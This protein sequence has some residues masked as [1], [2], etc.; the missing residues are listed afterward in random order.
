MTTARLT[1]FLTTSAVALA[2]AAPA[3]AQSDTSQTHQPPAAADTMQQAP[4]AMSDTG[5][6]DDTTM[7]AAPTGTENAAPPVAQQDQMPDPL[8]KVGVATGADDGLP[9]EPI[10]SEQAAGQLVS[11]DVIGTAVRNPEDEKI[12]SIDALV[13]DKRDRLIAGIISVGGFL[14]IGGKDVAVNWK[15]F[16]FDPDEDVAYVMLSREQLEAAPEFRTR[17]DQMA[18]ARAQNQGAEIQ[19]KQDRMQEQATPPTETAPA[20]ATD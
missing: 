4:A 19:A 5:T 10:L 13:F 6:A 3:L 17:E 2:L 14:G 15:E 1:R 8:K 9:A 16:K 11:D 20:N 12:G 7:K 18:E